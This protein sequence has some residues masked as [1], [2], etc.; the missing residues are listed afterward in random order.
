MLPLPRLYYNVRS[1]NDFTT[2]LKNFKRSEGIKPSKLWEQYNT[3]NAC[4][5]TIK[6]IY[7]NKILGAAGVIIMDEKIKQ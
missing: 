4:Y 3:T 5:N 7:Y 2:M 1:M 6:N